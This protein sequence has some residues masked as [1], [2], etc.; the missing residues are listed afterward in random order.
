[1]DV[2]SIVISR[3]LEFKVN[4]QCTDQTA[5]KCIVVLV[6]VVQMFTC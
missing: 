3:Y 1:M 5:L 2:P 4:N 6:C